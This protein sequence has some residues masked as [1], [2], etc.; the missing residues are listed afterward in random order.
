[1]RR[2]I[3]LTVLGLA[4]ASSL[5]F[6][7]NRPEKDFNFN[8]I[9]LNPADRILILAPHPDDEDLGCGGIIQKALAM[10]LPVK[11][12][13]FTYGDNNE[14]SFL[15]YRKRPVFM[16]MA[17]RN[18]GLLRHDEAVASARSWK[19]MRGRHIP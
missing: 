11:I 14:W 4:T 9:E 7:A 6:S 2:K 1:M 17:I 5:G 18:M 15:I 8:N 16:P 3:I 19:S 13:F 10:K 12:V